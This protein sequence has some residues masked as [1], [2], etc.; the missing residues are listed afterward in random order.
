MVTVWRSLVIVYQS[1]GATVVSSRDRQQD[2]MASAHVSVLAIF[3]ALAKVVWAPNG[4]LCLLYWTGCIIRMASAGLEAEAEAASAASKN[5]LLFSVAFHPVEYLI[6]MVQEHWLRI[7]ISSF[8]HLSLAV[9]FWQLSIPVPLCS[10]LLPP[11]DC[12][13]CPFC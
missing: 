9:V 2:I 12:P 1:H 13:F 5:Q 4:C 11:S 8:I 7:T 3:P 10:R 6:F